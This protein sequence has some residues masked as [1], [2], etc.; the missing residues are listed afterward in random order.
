MTI[1]N[2]NYKEKLKKPVVLLDKKL[3]CTLSI[4]IMNYNSAV[5]L[6]VKPS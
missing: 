2:Y 3:L 1:E 6:F 5:F 4:F